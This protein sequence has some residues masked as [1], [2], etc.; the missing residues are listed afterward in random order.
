MSW[1]QNF[2]V[3]IYIKIGRPNVVWC[4]LITLTDNVVRV[5]QLLP[6]IQCAY[7]MPPLTLSLK[8]FKSSPN[9][10]SVKL[11]NEKRGQK[12]NKQ[13]SVC[14]YWLNFRSMESKWLRW[15]RQNDAGIWYR[16]VHSE[17]W[18][19]TRE[20]KMRAHNIGS[21]SDMCIT[22]RNLLY[23]GV[24][25]VSSTFCW[26]KHPFINEQLKPEICITDKQRKRERFLV[27]IKSNV[28]F[29]S[30]F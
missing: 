26:H 25:R 5:S 13:W 23:S 14:L 27:L 24:K 30:D 6:L 1:L 29:N 8:W 15:S 17:N 28:A 4:P 22:S 20:R 7:K 9:E 21:C 2:S 18:S 12:K 19:D 3:V 11:F 10:S 16:F